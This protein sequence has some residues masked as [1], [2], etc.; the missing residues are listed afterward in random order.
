MFI[1]TKELQS[2][3]TK[4]KNSMINSLTDKNTADTAVVKT[5][6]SNIK[7]S[8]DEINQSI[9]GI[10]L[11]I[12]DLYARTKESNDKSNKVVYLETMINTINTQGTLKVKEL[13]RD[14]TITKMKI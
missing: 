13:K 1:D 14:C 5:D 8:N 6:I 4:L 3:I 10:N 12:A 2:E 11:K 7:S 9:K